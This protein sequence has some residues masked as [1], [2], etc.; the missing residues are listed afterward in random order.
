MRTE[1]IA[2]IAADPDYQEF[3]AE[4]ERQIT[5]KVM[6]AAT[7]PE[8]RAAA[9]AEYHGLRRLCARM[10]AIVHDEKHKKD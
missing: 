2:A 10:G 8:D 9:L 1:R 7:S 5:A 6:S 4:Q 3:V